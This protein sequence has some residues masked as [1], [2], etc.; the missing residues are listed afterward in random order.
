V[1]EF[2]NFL[3]TEEGDVWFG[4]LVDE[5]CKNT[6]SRRAPKF[7][8]REYIRLLHVLN[9]PT[10]A[11]AL[12]A[13]TQPRTRDDFEVQM[14]DAWTIFTE[15]FNDESYAPEHI[16]TDTNLFETCGENG[17]VTKV[18]DRNAAELKKHYGNLKTDF[19]KFYARWSAS[20]QS[21]D[22]GDQKDFRI[23]FLSYRNTMTEEMMDVH[24]YMF[25]FLKDKPSLD[26]FHRGV[27]AALHSSATAS[28]TP[29]DNDAD[30]ERRIANR[31]KRKRSGEHQNSTI[32]DIAS[33]ASEVYSSIS[34]ISK[35]EKVALVEKANYYKA[36]VQLEKRRLELEQK[37]AEESERRAEESERRAEERW[38][39]EKRR[40]EHQALQEKEQ[41][42]RQGE[43]AGR[44]ALLEK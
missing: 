42:G 28:G 22:Y 44:Q 36:N 14:V 2:E 29:L 23:D 9:D 20:G 12:A 41:A 37:R 6:E 39:L 13:I 10:T 8:A 40:I 11:H 26:M 17:R 3:E 5:A 33:Q 15:K 7:S 25:Y 35:E 30:I 24:E 18:H 34:A 19:T 32:V 1:S 4:K 31:K 16:T 38:Q 43:Q 21:D 27:P